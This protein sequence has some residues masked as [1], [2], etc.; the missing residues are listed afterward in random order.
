[1]GLRNV[2]DCW[3][4]REKRLLDEKLPFGTPS[5]FPLASFFSFFLHLF[6]AKKQK[7]R[8]ISGRASGCLLRFESH[9]TGFS[10]LAGNAIELSGFRPTDRERRSIFCRPTVGLYRRSDGRYH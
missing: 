4:E 1:M 8:Y 3:E 7:P 5:V 10:Q 9:K 2:G 6:F